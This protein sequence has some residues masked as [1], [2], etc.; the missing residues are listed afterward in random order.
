MAYEDFTTYT[1]VD[2]NSHLT[3]TANRI[4]SSSLTQNETAYV[5]KD[6]GV[7]YYNGALEFGLTVEVD[8][9]T[10]IDGSGGPL[11]FF[12]LTNDLNDIW[13]LQSTGKSLIYIFTVG[14]SFYASVR[15][16]G[17]LV[18][19]AI[20]N[21]PS[22]TWGTPYYLTVKRYVDYDASNDAI[23]IEVYSNSSRTTLIDSDI[24]LINKSNRD[25]FRYI[26]GSQ[27]FNTSGF[28]NILTSGF[29]ENLYQVNIVTYPTDANV[30]VTGITR[31]FWS[32]KGGQAQYLTQLTLGGFTSEYISP[33][34]NREP[35]P[36]I[37]QE[38]QTLSPQQIKGWTIQGGMNAN[39]G[40]FTPNVEPFAAWGTT[41]K[42]YERWLLQTPF[43]VRVAMFGHPM[44]Q[45]PSNY[46]EW[47]RRV[48]H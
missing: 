7:D 38:T 29:T 32:G 23:S 35:T 21:I 10:I 34:N 13:T 46:L 9:R 41:R 20:A 30:R 14:S 40:V 44:T 42:D 1:E 24:S 12:A 16:N 3:V 5:Y 37:P 26:H 17:T 22:F 8:N 19:E 15:H 28:N 31:T 33:V 43:E 48:T 6:K 4:T 47:V 2:P 36:V 11:E 25:S 18:G 45:D 27:S 39:Q